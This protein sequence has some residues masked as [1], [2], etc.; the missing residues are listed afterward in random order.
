MSTFSKNIQPFV[1][2]ELRAA[3]L[4][5]AS[6]FSYLERAHVL[7]QESTQQHVRVH[8]HMMLWGIRTRDPREVVG[9]VVRLLGAATKTVFGLVPTGNSGGSNV[10]P[11]ARMTVPGDLQRIMDFAK[12]GRKT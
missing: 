3:E 9:Q 8:W 7:G 1:S 4:D 10:S 12:S 6:G 2:A 5:P 11:F